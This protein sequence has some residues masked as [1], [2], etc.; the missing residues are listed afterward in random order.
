MVQ[1]REEC[2]QLG[3]DPRLAGGSGTA[4]VRGEEEEAARMMRQVIASL[5]GDIQADLDQVAAL[6]A[7][8]MHLHRATESAVYTF[9]RSHAWR[10]AAKAAAAGG[11]AQAV[12]PLEYLA[13]PVVLPSQARGPQGQGAAGGAA[14]PGGSRGAMR[15]ALRLPCPAQ[16]DLP[17][18]IS[19]PHR[20]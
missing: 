13:G 18:P 5:A 15:P 7:V 8:V 14:R 11:G 19:C 6:R 9:K 2:K 17:H 16:R 12:A 10:E 20:T 4:G 1:Y 3:G